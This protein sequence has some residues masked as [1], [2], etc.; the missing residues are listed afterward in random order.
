[1]CMLLSV[2]CLDSGWVLSLCITYHV[3]LPTHKDEHK[4]QISHSMC[5]SSWG[6]NC[7]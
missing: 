4:E 1:M 7:L 6:V 2:N 3:V 5:I